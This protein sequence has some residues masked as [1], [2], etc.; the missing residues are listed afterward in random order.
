V[1]EAL[2]DWSHGFLVADKFTP[3]ENFDWRQ[4][5]FRKYESFADFY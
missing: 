1:L 2:P 5:P 3:Q 4:Q